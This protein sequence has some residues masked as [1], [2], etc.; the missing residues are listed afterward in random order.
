MSSLGVRGQPVGAFGLSFCAH[1]GC[2]RGACASAVGATC[3]GAR[4]S[5]HECLSFSTLHRQGELADDSGR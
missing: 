2:V 1:W 4:A 3:M 5:V